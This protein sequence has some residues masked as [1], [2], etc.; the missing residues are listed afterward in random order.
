M[1]TYQIS[2]AIAL[3]IS[4][5]TRR[6]NMQPVKGTAHLPGRLARAMPARVPRTVDNNAA[7]TAA[8]SSAHRAYDIA[9]AGKR[10]IPVD[11]KA[12][13]RDQGSSVVERVDD[14]H[15]DWQEQ[16]ADYRHEPNQ[17]QAVP[18]LPDERSTLLDLK[19]ARS[20]WAYLQEGTCD[21]GAERPEP[22]E[23]LRRLSISFDTSSIRKAR[24]C[25]RTR[26][27]IRPT[28]PPTA[29]TASVIPTSAT[30]I[31]APFDQS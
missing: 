1:C 22:T 17:C 27:I 19:Y 14:D 23:L 25:R 20:R 24:R 18:N 31:A 10:F 13:P 2:N 28:K 12:R 9:V 30:A 5:V 11:P 3:T 4:G 26:R 15:N 8:L 6:R 16:K 21:G 29:T 7:P